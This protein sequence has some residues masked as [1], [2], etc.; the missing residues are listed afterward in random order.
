MQCLLCKGTGKLPEPKNDKTDTK[1][2]AARLLRNNGFTLHE[3][4]E[5]LGYEH[6][7]SVQHLL[8]KKI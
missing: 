2:K 7:G 5:T 3:I 4:R 8:K 1:A 6:I